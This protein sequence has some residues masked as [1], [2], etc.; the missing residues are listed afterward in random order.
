MMAALGHQG[1]IR[2]SMRLDGNLTDLSI[3]GTRNAQLI[4]NLGFGKEV[5]KDG[6]IMKGHGTEWVRMWTLTAAVWATSSFKHFFKGCNLWFDT[7]TA[8]N[9]GSIVVCDNR[10][11]LIRWPLLV[12]WPPAQKRVLW[13]GRRG[14][15]C[16]GST[17]QRPRQL[18]TFLGVL[19]ATYNCQVLDS[20]A[21][22]DRYDGGWR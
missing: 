16:W 9:S 4:L 8:L 13:R 22:G 14:R 6:S 12:R 17:N 11:S 10:I 19:I 2:P 3:R 20:G 21:T 15:S 7:T 18:A 1:L 5:R